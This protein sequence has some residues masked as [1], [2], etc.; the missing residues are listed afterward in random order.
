MKVL[1]LYKTFEDRKK[2]NQKKREKIK[3]KSERVESKID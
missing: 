1:L 3:K 2:K